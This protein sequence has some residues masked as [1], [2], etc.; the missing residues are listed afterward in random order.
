MYE[1]F[2][3]G[4]SVAQEGD[5]PEASLEASIDQLAQE[6]LTDVGTTTV[7]Q[8]NPQEPAQ[9]SGLQGYLDI[10]DTKSNGYDA[11]YEEVTLVTLITPNTESTF[12][13]LNTS[14]T[15]RWNGSAYV[16]TSA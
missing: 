10:G 2:G 8:K 9:G 13:D 3:I 15:Y 16:Q 4:F 5:I 14:V 12:T 7:I 11:F 6:I 1:G